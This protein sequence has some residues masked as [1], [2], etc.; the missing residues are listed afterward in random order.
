LK[1]MFCE[2]LFAFSYLQNIRR[3]QQKNVHN[4]AHKKPSGNTPEGFNATKQNLSDLARCNVKPDYT[5]D[6]PMWKSAIPI[7]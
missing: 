4:G 5:L 2:C 1:Y 7:L 6:K 3:Y